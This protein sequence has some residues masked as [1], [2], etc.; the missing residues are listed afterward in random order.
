MPLITVRTRSLCGQAGVWH[1]DET[2]P[3][4]NI[5]ELVLKKSN[6][7]SYSEFDLLHKGK[8]LENYGLWNKINTLTVDQN[9]EIDICKVPIVGGGTGYVLHHIKAMYRSVLQIMIEELLKNSGASVVDL[10]VQ[11]KHLA[12]LYERVEETKRQVYCYKPVNLE[13]PITLDP[14]ESI[15]NKVLWMQDG[16]CYGM[17]YDSM[18]K[19]VKKHAYRDDEGYVQIRNPYTNTPI[20]FPWKDDFYSTAIR[21]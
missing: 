18:V 5:F 16:K 12:C 14:L 15:K 21:T 7:T 6:H 10:E 2:T 3:I 20:P 13:D 17:A 1:L 8:A 9:G 4:A 11:R 19:Y